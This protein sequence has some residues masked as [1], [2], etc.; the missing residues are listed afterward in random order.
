MNSKT[1]RRMRE[2]AFRTY[3]G[4]CFWCGCKVTA[5]S[6]TLDHIVPRSAGG[7]NKQHNIVL[8]CKPCNQARGSWIPDVEESA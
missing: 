4:K 8:A 3:G 1:K 5:E 7:S 6:R 2:W